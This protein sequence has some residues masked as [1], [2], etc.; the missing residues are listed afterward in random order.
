MN[1]SQIQKQIARQQRLKK[2]AIENYDETIRFLRQEKKQ[3]PDAPVNL[4][5][6]LVRDVI[7]AFKPLNPSHHFFG[8]KNQRD[9]AQRLG[10]DYGLTKIQN[11]VR[12]ILEVEKDKQ[13]GKNPRS[14]FLPSITSP[15]EFEEKIKKLVMFRATYK[16]AQEEKKIEN[17]FFMNNPMSKDLK[18]VLV[19][20]EWKLFDKKFTNKIIYK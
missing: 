17:P 3:A 16:E 9:S 14:Q 15:A 4:E 20:G 19:D 18:K 11:M 12:F 1:K 7:D 13:T 6:G 5:N 8:R 10:N 2:K